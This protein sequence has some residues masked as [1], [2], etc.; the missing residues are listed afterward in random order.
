MSGPPRDGTG[1]GEPV[2]RRGSPKSRTVGRGAACA[3][4]RRAAGRPPKR[5]RRGSAGGSEAAPATPLSEAELAERLLALAGSY[6][7]RPSDARL[8]RHLLKLLADR[9]A[10]L[11]SDAR[12]DVKREVQVMVTTGETGA[13][14]SRALRRLFQET[15]GLAPSPCGRIRPY[16]RL[17]VR[18]PATLKTVGLELLKVLGYPL[19]ADAKEN[20]VWAKVLTHLRKAETVVLFLDEFQNCSSRANVDEAVRIRDTVKSLLVDE[21]PIIL[22]LA[23]LPEVVDFVRVDPQVRRRGRFTALE[24][25]DADDAETIRDAVAALALKVGLP[26]ANDLGTD[27]VPR[28]VHAACGQLGLAMEMAVEAIGCALRPVE[29]AVD[30]DGD[31]QEVVLPPRGAL[32]RA[33]FARMFEDRTGNMD[34]ANVFVADGW[35]EIDPTL[36]GVHLP[37]QMESKASVATPSRKGRGRKAPR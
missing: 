4:P 5:G 20:V 13:G 28:L 1:R 31:E 12:D 8:R 37:S 11:R 34:F 24:T 19:T 10:F 33:D 36:V 30:G 15:E 26:V 23:G 16:V 3:A 32:T 17:S 7:E 21:H 35:H 25:V 9:S 18:A 22:V 27:V 14:K 29:A 2:G 6:V